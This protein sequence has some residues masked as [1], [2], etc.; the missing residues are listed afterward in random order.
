M[1]FIHEIT[2][3]LTRFLVKLPTILLLILALFS[4]N[5]SKSQNPFRTYKSFEIILDSGEIVKTYIAHRPQEQSLGLSLVKADQF[6]DD[7]AMLFTGD[8]FEA[9]QF[10]MP[11]TFFDLDLFFLGP[12]LEVLDI[13]RKLKHHTKRKPRH[14]VPLS[15]VAYCQHV[16]ELKASSPLSAKIKI[17]MILKTNSNLQKIVQGIR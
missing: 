12:N 13:H 1:K 8:H 5:E 9:R 17:G 4:C 15:K 6:N 14:E 3:K 11:E 16:L 10:W 7:D 2:S